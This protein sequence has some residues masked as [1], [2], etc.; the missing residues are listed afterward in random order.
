M[1]GTFSQIYIHIIF[2][3]RGRENCISNTWNKKLYKYISGI[4]SNKG[5]K[6]IIVNGY[7]DHVHVFV[8]K[9]LLWQFLI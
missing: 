3:V 9:N 1:P 5:Q 8:G 2:A 7:T 6:A 4:I